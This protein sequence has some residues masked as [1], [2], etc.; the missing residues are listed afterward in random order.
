[1]S[2]NQGV[3]QAGGTTN[4]DTENGGTNTGP[5][6]PINPTDDDDKD[7]HVHGGIQG[8]VVIII[9]IIIKIIKRFYSLFLCS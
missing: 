3:N 1:M 7:D 9:M 6:T 5:I 2:K 8:N 4:K